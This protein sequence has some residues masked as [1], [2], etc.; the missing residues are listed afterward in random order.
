MHTEKQVSQY[1]F[2]DV[3]ESVHIIISIFSDKNIHIPLPI[4]FSLKFHVF[5]NIRIHVI[6]FT[7]FFS[8]YEFFELSIVIFDKP[9]ELCLL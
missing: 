1:H 2:N 4:Y 6:R 7:E 9:F 3:T 5:K 8:N